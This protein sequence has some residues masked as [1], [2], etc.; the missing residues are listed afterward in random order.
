MK[1]EEIREGI[2][3]NI[4]KACPQMVGRDI[5]SLADKIL[6]DEASQGVVIKVDEPS[7]IQSPVLD[8][9]FKEIVEDMKACGYVKVEPLI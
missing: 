7:G 1:Q 3:T 2:I 6:K 4:T 8:E 5:V 9:A